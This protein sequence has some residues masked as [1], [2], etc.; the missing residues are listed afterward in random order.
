MENTDF[1]FKEIIERVNDVVV[2]TNAAP[3]NY[4]GPEIVYVN[5]AFSRLTGYSSNE[6]IGKSPRIFH[7]PGTDV[8]TKK[9]IRQALEQQ[10]TI[11]ATI[12]NYAK[13]GREYWL[14]IQITPFKNREGE[15]T[16]FIAIERDISYQ[17]SMETLLEELA[18][19][20][21]LTGILNYRT[22]ISCLKTEWERTWRYK[23]IYSLVLVDIDQ[24]EKINNVHGCA[25]GD[26][27]IQSVAASCQGYLR[28]QDIIG[29]IGGEKFAIILPETSLE[30]AYRAAERMREKIAV[31]RILAN[32]ASIKVTVSMGIA[33]VSVADKEMETA[34][35]R[36]D[37][38]LYRAKCEGRNRSNKAARV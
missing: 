27:V 35:K 37:E 14:D 6:V 9:M 3:I 36:A 20:D 30:G 26:I 29:R 32:N 28:I 12:L 16:H 2:I 22:F 5:S 4:P 11:R 24:F 13:D 18:R 21:P 1:P 17:K 8:E 31:L 23:T 38:A 34:L 33:E 7:G 15:V 19:I 25:S 10:R